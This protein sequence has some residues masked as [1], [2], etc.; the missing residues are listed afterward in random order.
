[1]N[2]NNNSNTVSNTEAEVPKT[3]EMNDCDYLNDILTTEKSIGNNYS[4]VMSEASNNQFYQTLKQI[5]EETKDCGRTLFD[6]LFS[7]G[8]YRLEKAEQ[9]K[10]DTVNQ[11]YQQKLNELQ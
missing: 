11:E 5:H 7:K 8:W 4:T 9:T 3:P 6:L 10:I 1:M 2:N